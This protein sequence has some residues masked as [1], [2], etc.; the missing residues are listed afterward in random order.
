M[1]QAENPYASFGMGPVAQASVDVRAEFIRRTYLH[2]GGAVVLFVLLQ[3][4]I[5]T[6][7]IAENIAMSLIG[8]QFGWIA[9]LLAFMIVSGIARAMA[10]SATSLASQYAGLALYVVAEALIFVPLLYFAHQMELARN[11]EIIGPAAIITLLIFGGL[12]AVVFITAKD[13]SF[14]GSFLWV[15]SFGALGFILCAMIFGFSLGIVFSFAMVLLMS[16]WILYD[17]SNVM[18][19][20]Q[21]TQ[22]VAAS[23]A[24]FASLAVLFWYVLRIVMEFSRD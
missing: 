13:F 24:L 20:Y 22:Y 8:G 12:T 11:V 9:V 5:F 2:L 1:S 6:S 3:A 10:N 21:T 18:L 23:L 4:V 14:M 19:H 16:G 15:A 17:T 7:G